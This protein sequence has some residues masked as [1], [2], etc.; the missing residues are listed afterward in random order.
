MEFSSTTRFSVKSNKSF[1]GVDIYN[2]PEGQTL[3]F[4]NRSKANAVQVNSENEITPNPYEVPNEQI[5]EDPGVNKE[6][7]YEWFEKKKY[8]KLRSSDIK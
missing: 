3:K 6:K 8:R 4:I 7:I 1:Q 2:I 5:Y